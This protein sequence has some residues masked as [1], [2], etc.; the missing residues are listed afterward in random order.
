MNK[1]SKKMGKILVILT[2]ILMVISMLSTVFG[3]NNNNNPLNGFTINESQG[4]VIKNV[5]REIL[6]G[7]Q[8]ILSIGGVLYLIFIAVKYITSS[9]DGKAEIKK[10]FLMYTLGLV[11]IFGAAQILGLIAN[12]NLI[13]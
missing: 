1:L 4:G 2:Y 11:I 8:V 10:K 5:G 13:S 3:N 6:G 9:P 12:A 7:L